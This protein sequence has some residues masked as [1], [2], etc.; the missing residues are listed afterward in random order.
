MHDDTLFPRPRARS[1]EATVRAELSPRRE[2]AMDSVKIT[3]MNRRA[4]V[5]A[6]AAG[7][8]ATAF[9]IRRSLAKEAMKG[10]RGA[11]WYRFKIG[12]M[13]ATVV[14]DGAIGPL[15]VSGLYPKVP[16][17]DVDALAKGE[18][19][20]PEKFVVQENCLVLN[21]GD[22]LAL[23]DTG[24]G[25]SKA[26]GEGG[27]RLAKNLDAAGVKAEDIDV[28]ILSHGHLD[29]LSGIMGE[30]SKR[31]FPSAQIAV[32]KTEFDFWTDEGKVS[33]T[34]LMKLLVDSARAN[35][36]PN[37]DRLAFVE[38]GKEVIKGVQAI[39]SPGHTPGHTS[40]ILSSAGQN[41]LYTGDIAHTFVQF[42]HPE[43]VMSLDIDPITASATRKR[44]IDMAAA[45]NLTVIV[46]H[47]AFPG[48]G[49]V[50]RDGDAFRF[51]AAPMEL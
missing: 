20:S 49:R 44:M 21:T 12:D 19:L 45:E 9:D 34:G 29:H 40:Y 39:S 46:Y 13:E 8:F 42:K 10:D 30:G 25:R 16:K 14:S 7:A 15:P 47:L 32:S 3:S 27:G 6:S 5:A 17:E 22:Q 33:A 31:F 11:A 37:K 1:G 23:I 36:L 38:D 51:V 43:W 26:F 4:F 2:S 48:I 35:L 28:I 50:A 41:V 18:F 24:L